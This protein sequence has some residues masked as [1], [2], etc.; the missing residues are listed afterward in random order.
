MHLAS[1]HTQLTCTYYPQAMALAAAVYWT[2]GA[3]GYSM[4]KQRTSGDVLRNLGGA[5]VHG[6]RGAYERGLK[7]CYALAV[8]ASIPLVGRGMHWCHVLVHGG[9]LG[10]AR[11]WRHWHPFAGAWRQASQACF[12]VHA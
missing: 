5:S 1:C 8:L 10:L 7:G 9:A 4:F 11:R 3:G 2:V 6:M 12:G